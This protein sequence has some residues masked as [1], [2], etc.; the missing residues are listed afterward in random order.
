LKKY[1]KF[2][3]G[4]VDDTRA[5]FSMDENMELVTAHGEYRTAWSVQDARY[6]VAGRAWQDLGTGII[7]AEEAVGFGPAVLLIMPGTL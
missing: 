7:A 2:V 3:L 4:G 5:L 6:S 1:L